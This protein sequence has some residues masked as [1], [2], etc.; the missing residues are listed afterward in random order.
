MYEG[1]PVVRRY[2]FT[3]RGPKRY[4]NYRLSKRFEMSLET[5]K[6]RGVV[7]SSGKETVFR[8]CFEVFQYPSLKVTGEFV[9]ASIRVMSKDVAGDCDEER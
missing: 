5:F 3:V 4:L 8:V 7:G 2:F 9:P 1:K 6:K